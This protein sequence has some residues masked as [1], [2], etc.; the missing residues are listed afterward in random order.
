[1]SAHYQAAVDKA[2]AILLLYKE[3]H[4][5]EAFP[6]LQGKLLPLIEAQAAAN[7]VDNIYVKRFKE[8]MNP[9]VGQVRRIQESNGVYAPVEDHAIIYLCPS[10]E[11]EWHRFLLV[12]EASHVMLDKEED[13]VHTDTD[14]DDLLVRFAQFGVHEASKQYTSEMRAIVCA[15]ELLFPRE[16]RLRLQ[17]QYDAGK[18]SPAAIAKAARVPVVYVRMA[19]GQRYRDMIE[20]LYEAMF[21]AQKE[22]KLQLVKKA[23][24]K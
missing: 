20:P 22:P 12:K 4:P 19:M 3:R 17:E 10:L 2:A 16:V 18:I 6:T 21:E 14:I 7:G 15:I 5:G 8:S 9:L 23:A 24:G 11:L 1:M 13:F